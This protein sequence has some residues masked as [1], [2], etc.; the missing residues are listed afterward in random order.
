MSAKRLLTRSSKRL[1]KVRRTDAAGLTQVTQPTTRPYDCPLA[2]DWPARL[3]QILFSFSSP[4][5]EALLQ[6]PRYTKLGARRTISEAEWQVAGDDHSQDA[7][8]ADAHLFN[9]FPCHIHTEFEVSGQLVH[10]D[11]TWANLW[12]PGRLKVEW[13][14]FIDG[15]LAGFGGQMGCSLGFSQVISPAVALLRDNQAI[16]IHQILARRGITLADVLLAPDQ[17][18]LEFAMH[19]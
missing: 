14:I 3:R 12:G 15:V 16:V 19:A 4:G 5:E 8:A 13:H 11:R 10:I 7:P 6:A 9:G 17:I 2:P 1:A 18:T